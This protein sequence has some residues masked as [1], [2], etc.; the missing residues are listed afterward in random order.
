MGDKVETKWVA[1]GSCK[2]HGEQ[3]CGQ[4]GGQSKRTAALVGKEAGKAASN[5][6]GNVAV[7]VS[8]WTLGTRGGGE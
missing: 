4:G 1:R 8:G 6:V 7:T 5:T 2:Q 3:H